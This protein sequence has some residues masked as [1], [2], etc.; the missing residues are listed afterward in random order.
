MKTIH[1]YYVYILASK[2]YGTLYIGV[3]NDLQRR[4]F[5][6][7]SKLIKGFTSKYNIHRLVYFESFQSIDEAILREKRLKK[8]N[9]SWKIELIEK[10]NSDWKDLSA[11]WYENYQLD[12]R[13]LGNDTEE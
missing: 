11:Q 5:E 6:H 3:T 10:D 13:F 9:R 4:V 2:F 1:Q 8:W 12:S 7:K